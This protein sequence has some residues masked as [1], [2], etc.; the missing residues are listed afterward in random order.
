MS[1][2][3]TVIKNNS[4]SEHGFRVFPGYKKGGEVKRSKVEPVRFTIRPGVNEIASD[5]WEAVMEKALASKKSVVQWRLEE[6]I[7]EVIGEDLALDAYPLAKMKEKEAVKV[8]AETYS[9][10]LLE[11]WGNAE[12]RPRVKAAIADQV[13]KLELPSKK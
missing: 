10:E 2:T 13:K 12:K 8:V 7:Y 6:G 3:K 1:A 11:T 4:M 9:D 5:L